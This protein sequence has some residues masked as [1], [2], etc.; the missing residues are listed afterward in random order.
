LPKKLENLKILDLGCGSGWYAEQL[1]EAGAKV[2]AMDVSSTMVE[3]TKLRLKGRGE[4]I[5]T[6]LEQ[7]LDFFNSGAFDI[8][9]APLVIHYIQTEVRYYHR[10]LHDLIEN[11]VQA[12]F[13]IEKLLEPQP[14][15]QLKQTAP[16]MFHSITTQPWFLFVRA[17]NLRT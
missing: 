15:S 13:I 9:L 2:T 5:V 8:V 16:E 6:D 3:L 14:L 17:K 1:L 12:E 7:P 10:S 11:L 4:F